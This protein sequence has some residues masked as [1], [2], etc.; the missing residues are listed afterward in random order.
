MIAEPKSHPPPR[1]TPH[2][3]QFCYKTS[4]SAKK[5]K[6]DTGHIFLLLLERQVSNV[7]FRDQ[8]KDPL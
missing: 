3:S 1:I 8:S 2:G 6:L 5:S 7:R 4:F